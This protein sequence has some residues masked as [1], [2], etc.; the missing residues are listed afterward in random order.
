MVILKKIQAATLLEVLT[1]SVLIIIVFM[2]ASLSF[3]TIFN[4]QIKRNHSTIENRVK[5]IEYLSIHEKIKIPYVE[6][7]DGWEIIITP[8]KNHMVLSY[9]RKSETYTK[10]LFTK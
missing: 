5:E 2:I 7:F 8:V 6:D 1:A 4:T 10:L 3:N 9:S